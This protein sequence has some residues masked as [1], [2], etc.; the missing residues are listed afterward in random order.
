M[1]WKLCRQLVSISRYYNSWTWFCRDLSLKCREWDLTE[2][3]MVMNCDTD[4][5]NTFS[6]TTMINAS[7]FTDN[8]M[9]IAVN[10]FPHPTLS[11]LFNFVLTIH[12]KQIWY[13]TLCQRSVA[14]RSNHPLLPDRIEHGYLL[15]H[16]ARM[17][18]CILPSNDDKR[19][20]VYRQLHKYSC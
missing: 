10:C 16:H 15:R 4:I 14:C 18:E 11:I 9:N 13:F 12:N 1:L 19:I 8:Y 2:A 5:M 3:I 6:H 17:H 7:L 20:I